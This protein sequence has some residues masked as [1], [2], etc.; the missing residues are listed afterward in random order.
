MSQRE[1]KS[2]AIVV[3]LVF[4]GGF[5]GTLARYSLDNTFPVT[6]R[7]WPWTTFVINIVGAF[8]L[9]SLLECLARRPSF[10]RGQELRLLLGTGFCGAFTT[11]SSL[12][13]ETH[14][15]IRDEHATQA[16]AYMFTSI[17]SGLLA[18]AA[19]IVLASKLGRGEG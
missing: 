12:A 14:A 15:L 1:A 17:A 10:S 3:V 4:T 6:P 5:L 18:C 2:R 11:Y 7:H 9:G 8:A 16:A 13:I 19:G